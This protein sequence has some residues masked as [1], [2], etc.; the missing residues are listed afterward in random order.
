MRFIP[1]AIR[2]RIVLA[3]AWILGQRI[4]IPTQTQIAEDERIKRWWNNH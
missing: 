4:R 1:Y 2:R 3:F